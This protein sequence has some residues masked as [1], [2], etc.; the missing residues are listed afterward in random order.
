VEVFDPASTRVIYER[1]MHK[2]CTSWDLSVSNIPVY[3]VSIYI[4]SVT[5]E[6]KNTVEPSFDVP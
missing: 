3:M 1:M 4:Q 6:K 2:K 5:P